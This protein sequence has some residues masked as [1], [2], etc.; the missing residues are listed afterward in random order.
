M[1]YYDIHIP[2]GVDTT[3][4]VKDE[5]YYRREEGGEWLVEVRMDEFG[6]IHT[7][8]LMYSNLIIQFY[9]VL[10]STEQLVAVQYCNVQQFTLMWDMYSTLIYRYSTVQSGATLYCTVFVLCVH[11]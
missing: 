5:G 7:I 10:Y 3:Y 9:T 1:H 2:C 11:H 8:V 6:W 4:E